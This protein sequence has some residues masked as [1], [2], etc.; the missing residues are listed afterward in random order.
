V[1]P[2]G[3]TGSKQL[4]TP[5]EQFGELYGV[6]PQFF[7]RCCLLPALV[8]VKRFSCFYR[9][10]LVATLESPAW[11]TR[12]GALRTVLA[13][14]AAHEIEEKQ[15]KIPR[16]AL[17]PTELDTI[18][19]AFLDTDWNGITPEF[20]I[21]DCLKPALHADNIA[22]FF[23]LGRLVD[24]LKTRD[25]RTQLEALKIAARA[26]GLYADEYD[27]IHFATHRDIAFLLSAARQKGKQIQIVRQSQIL[28]IR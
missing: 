17:A 2:K 7:V 5:A 11:K 27:N 14:M 4:T 28:Y 12:L 22:Y 8:A 25:S 1:K 15:I 16:G 19:D 21:A 9:G 26:K 24:S 20:L 3:T 10:V 6:T 13:I 18:A 23:Y